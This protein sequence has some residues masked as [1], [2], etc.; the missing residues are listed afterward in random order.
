M[1]RGNSLY[2]S[3]GLQ[4]VG[5][6]ARFIAPGTN[7][8]VVPTARGRF[9]RDRHSCRSGRDKSRP[10]I[11]DGGALLP[12]PRSAGEISKRRP[13]SRTSSCAAELSVLS[14]LAAMTQSAPSRANLRAIAR[15]MPRLPP[16]MTAT[17]P[18]RSRSMRSH[19]IEMTVAR[20]VSRVDVRGER[21]GST[22]PTTL[23]GDRQHPPP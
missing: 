18:S 2:T 13:L 17:L 4:Y 16:L 11:L 14:F 19:S 22:R 6:R 23:L 1:A 21:L 7:K 9:S 5:K 3:S 8:S 12:V 10:Y 15:P 20:A